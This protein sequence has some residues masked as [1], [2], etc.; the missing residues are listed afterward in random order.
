M[1][2]ARAIRQTEVDER[3][4]AREAIVRERDDVAKDM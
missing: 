3:E 1:V 2:K 4:A